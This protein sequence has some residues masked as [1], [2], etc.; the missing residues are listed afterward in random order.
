M[1]LSLKRAFFLPLFSVYEDG[2]E[3]HN[4]GDFDEIHRNLHTDLMKFVQ[5]E[6]KIKPLRLYINFLKHYNEKHREK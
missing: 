4:E 1:T 2:D 5:P 3:A 6:T